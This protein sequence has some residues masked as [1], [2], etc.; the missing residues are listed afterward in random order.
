MIENNESEQDNHIVFL[1]V[2]VTREESGRLVTSMHRK[3]TATESI[4]AFDSNHPIRHNIFCI[5]TPWDRVK[6]HCKSE[7]AKHQERRHQYNVF[8]LNGNPR[9]NVG[10]NVKRRSANHTTAN[11]WQ[12]DLFSG[13][14]IP[15]RKGVLEGATGILG[16][17][18]LQVGHKTCGRFDSR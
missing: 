4:L 18:G 10:Q 7:T 14:S 5:R 1:D 9:N 11:T 12:N 8:Q 15:Y 17:H 13:S 16:R 2:L 3:P 6:T